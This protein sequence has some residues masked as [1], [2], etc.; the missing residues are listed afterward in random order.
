MKAWG[1]S[2][3]AMG[4][5]LAKGGGLLGLGVGFGAKMFM[6]FESW[7][8]RAKVLSGATAGEFGKLSEE[9]LRLGRDTIFT[10]T[11][12]AKTM[13]I[14]AQAGLK[15]ND[16][17]GATGPT[18]DLAA[19]G[20][21]DMATAADITLK[22]MMGMGLQT[23]D[24]K[25]TVDVLT[26]AMTTANTDLVQLGEAF[27]YVGPVAKAAGMSL[28]ETTAAIQM[29][30]NAGIQADMAGTTLRGMVLQLT[31]TSKE[32]QAVLDELGVKTID[33]LTGKFRGFTT[34]VSDLEK[35]M[36]GMGSGERLQRLGTI[37]SARQSAGAAELLSQGGGKMLRFT[38]AL[39]R[40]S[41]R[42]AEI[43]AAQLDTLAGSWKI[44]TSSLEGVVIGVGRGVAPLL[45]QWGEA[46]TGA[47]NAVTLMV[48]KNPE[49]FKTLAK[50]AVGVAGLGAAMVALGAVVSGSA[51]VV[52][53]LT[54]T[55][56]GLAFVFKAGLVLYTRQWFVALRQ[57]T[58][59]LMIPGAAEKTASAMGKMTQALRSAAASVG[60][61]FRSMGQEVQV[62]F[63]GIRD[64]MATGGI[65]EAAQIAWLGVKV[66]WLQGVNY[67][68]GV[69]DGFTG[70]FGDRVAEGALA[71]RLAWIEFT[72]AMVGDW[73]RGL[74]E[75]AAVWDFHVG[76]VVG[77]WETAGGAITAVID[78]VKDNLKELAMVA[79]AAMA[80]LALLSAPGLALGAATY[81]GGSAAAGALG[82]TAFY[83]PNPYDEQRRR[84]RQEAEDEAWDEFAGRAN[85]QTFAAVE[86]DRQ[87]RAV[88][89]QLRQAVARPK[90]ARDL[91][92]GLGDL[93]RL[94]EVTLGYFGIGGGLAK[95]ADEAT[96]GLSTAGRMEAAGQFGG[97]GAERSLAYGKKLA[98]RT[99]AAAE[100]TAKNT[101]KMADQGGLKAV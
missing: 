29:L 45:R 67:L 92:E 2:V 37:F 8:A 36:A 61:L 60:G 17:L 74:D 10:A 89:E 68:K 23:K 16:I 1:Q 43:A 93:K 91:Q 77:M 86:R 6:D 59:L 34:I 35:A 88:Q 57:T 41:G 73:E 80:P 9:A 65:Q 38:E 76:V 18:L 100:E 51:A 78:A 79:G 81:Y 44:L 63:A 40:A 42:A 33:P 71:A 26:A 66:V 11:D 7:M 31:A 83:G 3:Q 22:V 48:D 15:A 101:K 25:A 85:E 24:L 53:L 82:P 52:G 5:V 97:F 49:L 98:E 27:K 69:W 28:E 39:S 75:V 95:R 14:F 87:V 47:A 30:S 99:A 20:M 54:S 58:W 21:L 46:L 50:V 94:G 84:R 13:S 72:A 32:S 96:R 4:M 12:A 56:A 62:A 19:A 90:A 70:W 55:L 64:A